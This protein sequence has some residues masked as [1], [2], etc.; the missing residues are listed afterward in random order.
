MSNVIDTTFSISS[1]K[2][3]WILIEKSQGKKVKH[4]FFSSIQ[5]LSNFVGEYKLREFLVKGEVDLL[6]KSAETPSYSSV[7]E[8]S[9]L[10]L[11]QYIESIVR[12]G[13]QS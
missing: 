11:E 7:I 8:Q 6:D 2:Y 10:K 9:V 1:D 5:Q 12:E 4:H 13:G 3:N